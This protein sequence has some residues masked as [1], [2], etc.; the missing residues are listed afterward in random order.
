MIKGTGSECWFK[1]EERIRASDALV[2]A[3][4]GDELLMK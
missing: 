2:R 3:L 4:F 1:W